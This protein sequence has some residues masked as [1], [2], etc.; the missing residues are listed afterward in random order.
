[1]G[2]GRV[3][4]F[5]LGLSG[6]PQKGPHSAR[7]LY[8]GGFLDERG[9]VDGRGADGLEGCCH[10]VG[11]EASREHDGPQLDAGR[12]P[13][14]VRFHAPAPAAGPIDVQAAERC[15]W[16]SDLHQGISLLHQLG[17][18]EE[19]GKDRKRG[20]ESSPRLDAEHGLDDVETKLQGASDA[21]DVGGSRDRHRECSFTGR[22]EVRDTASVYLLGARVE[23]QAHGIYTEGDRRFQILGSREPAHLD[24][25]THAWRPSRRR[26]ACSMAKDEARFM[27]RALDLAESG[28]GTV[29]PN[30]SVG[31]VIVREGR[32]VG[33]GRTQL[34]GRPHAEVIALEAAGA[35]AEGATAYVSLEP[36]CH[37]GQT[38]P[39][40]DALIRARVARVVVACLDPDP[41][42]NGSGIRRLQ[43][44][45]IQVSTGLLGDRGRQINAGFF[46]RIRL[47]RPFVA[48]IAHA[49]GI[50]RTF[51]AL[52]S[53]ED[54]VL[55]ADEA[56]WLF[57]FPGQVAVGP[58]RAFLL[59]ASPATPKGL[60]DALRQLAE[61][62]LTRL[63]IS[64]PSV[65]SAAD[66]L[67]ILDEQS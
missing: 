11:S 54:Q 9:D 44:A 26:I 10:V 31:A 19:Y 3:R 28:L 45:G 47:G 14:P 56:P 23:D 58:G 17:T 21:V 46:A 40:T 48:A 33:E 27:E 50:P 20:V 66:V 63:A 6:G 38:P 8:A 62:G 42:V 41:R 53:R 64:A 13:A 18:I 37:W 49:A 29:W 52:W 4:A 7:R 1:M 51:D 15:R 12:G 57:E 67:G 55:I 16:T 2:E 24:P 22:Q 60:Q 32:V 5:A 61:A 36:C 65:L 35:A 43:R 59:S 30:P 34:R 39:C 25:Y